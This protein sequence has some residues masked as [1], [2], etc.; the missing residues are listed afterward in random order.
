ML[1]DKTI[2][3]AVAILG[4]TILDSV[5]LLNGIDGTVLS[6]SIAGIAGIGGYE[7]GNLKKKNAGN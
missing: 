3:G 7:I 1:S 6:L 5:A 4:I 2:L